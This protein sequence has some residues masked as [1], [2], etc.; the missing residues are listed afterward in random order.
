MK[1]PMFDFA[2]AMPKDRIFWSD[3][4]HVNARGARMKA[5]L[6]AQFLVNNDLVPPATSDPPIDTQ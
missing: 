4:R 1:V 3:S 6:F 5:E 2:N